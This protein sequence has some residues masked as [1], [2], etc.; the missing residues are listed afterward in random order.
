M[1]LKSWLRT[2]PTLVII[3]TVLFLVL[4]VG[5]GLLLWGSGFAHDMVHSQLSEQKISFPAKGSPGLDPKE[6]PGLQRYA[7]QTVDNGP[8]AKAYADQFIKVHLK[9]IANGQTYSQVSAASLANP[10]DAKLAGEVQ[11][12]FRGETLRGLLLYGWGWSVVGEIAFFAGIA[13]LLGALAVLMALII[14]FATHEHVVHQLFAPTP[15]VASRRS[16]EPGDTLTAR[17]TSSTAD[18]EDDVA[19]WEGD[20]VLADGA[21]VHMRAMRAD[22]EPR[23]AQM[24]ERLSSDSVYLPVLLAGAACDRDLARVE[25]ARRSRPRRAGRGARRRHRRGRPLRRREAGCGRGRLRRRRRASGPRG[26]HAAARAPRGDRPVAGYPHVRGRHAARQRQD[27]RHVR[28]RRLGP[29]LPFRRRDGAHA[30][31]DRAEP[32][33]DRRDRRP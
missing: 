28:G 9:G 29:R 22:D 12:L 7:G 3:G 25:P 23:L 10:K 5:S 16:S 26:R 14:G 18:N 19:D 17:M 24:Y 20:V 21:T 32:G 8:K 27:A 30:V 6:F 13:A 2:V 31:L 1:R 11:T 15:P 33:V 4:S